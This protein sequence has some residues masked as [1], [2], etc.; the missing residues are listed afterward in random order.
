MD[1][2]RATRKYHAWLRVCLATVGIAVLVIAVWP[3]SHAAAVSG[4]TNLALTAGGGAPGAS[5]NATIGVIDNT[6]VGTIT[7]RNLPAQPFGSGRFYGVWYVRNDNSKAFLGALIKRESIIFS[8]GGSGVMR[9]SATKF[10][11]G[12]AVG[13]PIAFGPAGTNTLVVLIENVL[14]GLTPAPV[15]PVPGSG[16]A[17][18][19]MF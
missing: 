2:A 16:V 4:A 6:V 15:G 12:P 13:S 9:F 17:V 3:G 5:G 7:V 19:G 14:N 11:D 8:T 18:V 1:A 10:T